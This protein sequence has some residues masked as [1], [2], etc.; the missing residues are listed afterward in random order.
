MQDNCVFCKIVNGELPAFRVY[1]D[2]LFLGLLDIFPV[3]EGHSILIPKKHYRWVYDVPEFGLYWEAAKKIGLATLREMNAYS[4]N[5]LT[6]GDEVPH[7]HIWIIPRQKADRGPIS[8]KRLP[9]K[10]PEE[11]MQE[12]AAK[13]N[14][15]FP[16]E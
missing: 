16:Q 8:V 13:I 10:I 15:Q 9:G 7:A 2:D 5:Y 4:I 1:E 6:I 3:I 11:R 14:S 12:I